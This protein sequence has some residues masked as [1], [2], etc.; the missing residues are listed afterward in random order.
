[1][2]DPQ[3]RPPVKSDLLYPIRKKGGVCGPLFLQVKIRLKWFF[4][5]NTAK[6]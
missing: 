2:G 5:E 1:M 6:F 3:D 4:L